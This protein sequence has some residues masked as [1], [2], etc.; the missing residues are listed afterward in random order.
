MKKTHGGRQQKEHEGDEVSIAAK[1]TLLTCPGI[2][3]SGMPKL[4][5]IEIHGNN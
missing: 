3:R 5:N 1:I 4:E 2:G